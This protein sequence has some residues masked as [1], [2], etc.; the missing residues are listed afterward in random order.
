MQFQNNQN[1][2]VFWDPDKAMIFLANIDR[3][4][5]LDMIENFDDLSINQVTTDLK[6]ILIDSAKK[7]FPKFKPKPNKNKLLCYS[8]ETKRK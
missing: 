1:D 4:K 5:V 3:G 6:N 8:K 2:T 7:S